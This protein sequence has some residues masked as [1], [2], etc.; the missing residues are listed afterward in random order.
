MIRRRHTLY[1]ATLLM[2]FSPLFRMP[3]HAADIAPCRYAML[4]RY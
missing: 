4:L 2:P 1:D 3:C